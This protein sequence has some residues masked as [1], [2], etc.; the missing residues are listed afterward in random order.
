MRVELEYVL[1]WLGI[2][3][4]AIEQQMKNIQAVNYNTN[5][6]IMWNVQSNIMTLCE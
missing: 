4:M 2:Q 5:Q 1:L 3:N 6:L